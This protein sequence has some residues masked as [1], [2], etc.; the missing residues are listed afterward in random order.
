M[1]TAMQLTFRTAPGGP[2]NRR[3]GADCAE[4]QFGRVTV[5]RHTMWPL[6]ENTSSGPPIQQHAPASQAVLGA[7]PYADGFTAALA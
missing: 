7:G 4:C 3:H 1:L 2:G 5:G 6:D